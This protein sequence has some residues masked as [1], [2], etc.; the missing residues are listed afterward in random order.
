MSRSREGSR[1]QVLREI[2]GIILIALVGVG[3]LF[4][5]GILPVLE[6]K[7]E[8]AREITELERSLAE[9][10]QLRPVYAEL[11]AMELR[12][13]GLLEETPVVTRV[14]LAELPE[15]ESFLEERLAAQGGTL[16]EFRIRLGTGT[17]TGRRMQ[18][19]EVELRIQFGAEA[20]GGVFAA[21]G[22]W[23]HWRRWRHFTV[24]P[25]NEGL[26]QLS[27]SLEVEVK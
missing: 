2:G 25:M 13:R 10:E 23:T 5:G 14:G 6:E 20:M 19:A 12:L 16:R 11:Q 17:G 22:D 9:A 26:W 24:E 27:C 4:F 18:T 15:Q 1:V 3:V 8:V 7:Q 21:L